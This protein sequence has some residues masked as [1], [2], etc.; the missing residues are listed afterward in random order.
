M[1]LES[2]V[3]EHNQASLKTLDQVCQDHVLYVLSVCDGSK[4]ATARA[5]GITVKTLYNYLHKWGLTEQYI[6]PVS[7]RKKCQSQPSHAPSPANTSV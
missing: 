5:L 6:R 4:W 1:S 2:D 7:R 3:K